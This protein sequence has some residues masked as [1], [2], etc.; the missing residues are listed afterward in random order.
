MR[1]TAQIAQTSILRL[2]FDGFCAAQNWW[3]CNVYLINAL[4]VWSF[5]VCIWHFHFQIVIY[6]PWNFKFWAC[7]LKRHHKAINLQGVCF[8]SLGDPSFL[9]FLALGLICVRIVF[10]SILRALLGGLSGSPGVL[11]IEITLYKSDLWK[12][13]RIYVSKYLSNMYEHLWNMYLS[14]MRLWLNIYSTT[15][16]HVCFPGRPDSRMYCPDIIGRGS[17]VWDEQKTLYKI[18]PPTGWGNKPSRQGLST[19]REWT[20]RRLCEVIVVVVIVLVC[21]LVDVVA[22]VVGGVVESYCFLINIIVEPGVP[23]PPSFY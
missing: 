10:L 18:I 11:F 14:F 4:R 16:K 3:F 22:V 17:W 5:I 8:G 20:R 15:I 7:L 23:R 19:Q 12:T 2:L 6:T 1:F 13:K 9:C 21:I